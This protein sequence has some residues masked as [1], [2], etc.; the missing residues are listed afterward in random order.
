MHLPLS[1]PELVES[2]DQGVSVTYASLQADS[3]GYTVGSGFARRIF[4]EGTTHTFSFTRISSSL[5]ARID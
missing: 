1:L 5:P 3:G 4:G 2:T